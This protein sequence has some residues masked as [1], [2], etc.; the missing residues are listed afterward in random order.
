MNAL[1]RVVRHMGISCWT[2]E[3]RSAYAGIV[4]GSRSVKAVLPVS[5]GLP[6]LFHSCYD[7]GRRA[8]ER[9]GPLHF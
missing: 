1:C 4:G 2:K 7:V 3:R 5:S 6:S 9:L 8:D